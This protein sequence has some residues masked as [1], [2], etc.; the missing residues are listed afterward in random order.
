MVLQLSTSPFVSPKPSS[1]AVGPGS[2]NSKAPSSSIVRLSFLNNTGS[3][4]STQGK[5]LERRRH[6]YV[7]QPFS[8]QKSKHDDQPS[9]Q[10]VLEH[11]AFSWDSKMALAEA[12]K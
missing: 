7:V 4:S 12:L 1:K 9:K 6:H 8:L 3:S 11:E 2:G 10:Q 5:S